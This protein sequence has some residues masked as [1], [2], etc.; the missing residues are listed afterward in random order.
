VL[1][2]AHLVTGAASSPSLRAATAS[3]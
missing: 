2:P 1:G 3:I